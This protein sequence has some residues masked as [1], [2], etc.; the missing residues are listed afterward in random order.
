MEKGN[1]AE[2]EFN[3]P[4]FCHPGCSPRLPSPPPPPPPR[5]RGGMVAPG[6]NEGHQ[7]YLKL[8]LQDFPRRLL[9]NFHFNR[10]GESMP[11]GWKLSS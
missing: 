4:A 1:M 5:A 10:V 6:L 7:L 11:G 3:I 8:L 9:N 2:S